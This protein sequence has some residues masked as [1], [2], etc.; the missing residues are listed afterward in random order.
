MFTHCK[1]YIYRIT[2][3]LLVLVILLFSPVFCTFYIKAAA[4]SLKKIALL[5]DSMTWIGGDSCQNPTGWS[6]YLKQSGVAETIDVY[7]RSGA[8]WTNTSNT[9][10]DTSFYSEILH[11]NNVI[12][13]QVLRLL[14]DSKDT[15]PDCIIIFAGANDAWFSS[16]RPGIFDSNSSDEPIASTKSDLSTHYNED[17]SILNRLPKA[18]PTSLHSSVTFVCD[19]LQQSFPSTRV[20]LVTPLQMSKVPVEDIL[21]V[22][23]IIETSGESKGC[24]IL[25]ADKKAGILHEV[26]SKSPKYTYDGVHTNP[27]GARLVADFLL[28]HLLSLFSDKTSGT[29]PIPKELNYKF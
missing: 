2:P 19:M 10:P 28:P 25:R 13:N 24:V 20:I 18:L 14:A 8:T 15:K 4:P 21:K 17:C 26:E 3:H 5:G 29:M 9:Y 7:A 12:F 1:S 23:D 16:R 6:Y 27:E 11:D 22:S